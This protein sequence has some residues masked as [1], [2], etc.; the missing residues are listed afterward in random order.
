MQFVY[1]ADDHL[2]ATRW[3]NVVRTRASIDIVQ[4]LTWNDYG[5]SHYLKD[6]TPADAM[7]P[8]TTWVAGMPHAGWR[9]L[10]GYY[11]QAFKTGVYPAVQADALYVW[12][13]PHF[14]DAQA[15]AD[16]L[17]KPTSAALTQ[18]AFWAVVLAR[19]PGTVT[20]GAGATAQSFAVPAGASKLSLPITPGAGMRATLSRGD[21][22]VLELAP[23]GFVFQGSPAT[24]NYNAF[25]AYAKANST[26]PSS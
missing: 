13:R 16:A 14:R 11:A 10:A 17:A 22:T 1:L 12:A 4:L 5:E 6:P 23:D 8:G 2:F 9:D 26:A 24:Y 19:A 7:P 25:V 3:E 20:L 15:S 18:D 21:A